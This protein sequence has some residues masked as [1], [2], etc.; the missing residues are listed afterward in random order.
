MRVLRDGAL[1][2]QELGAV[3]RSTAA[4]SARLASRDVRALAIVSVE[5]TKLRERRDACM[6]RDLFVRS[7]QVDGTRVEANFA[8]LVALAVLRTRTHTLA[9]FAAHAA[10]VPAPREPGNFL[11]GFDHEGL[12]R[13]TDQSARIEQDRRRDARA[14]AAREGPDLHPEPFALR[15]ARQVDVEIRVHEREFENVERWSDAALGIREHEQVFE[16]CHR[17]PST[18]PTF[19]RPQT[20]IGVDPHAPSTTRTSTAS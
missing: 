19:V 20:V 2:Q 1:V 4:R 6:L 17:T 18:R 10:K 14:R 12:R 3:G 16:R 13:S 15:R 5:L 7:A 11:A 9:D 8:H